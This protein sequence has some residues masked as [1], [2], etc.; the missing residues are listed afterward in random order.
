MCLE[1]TNFQNSIE[2]GLC[3]PF[4]F[5]Q[6]LCEKAGA[7]VYLVG[8][9]FR[10]R[11]RKAVFVETISRFGQVLLLFYAV[12][13]RFCVFLIAI[14]KKVQFCLLFLTVR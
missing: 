1:K 8:V 7:E 11:W 9:V 3:S 14:Q 13:I 2:C 5:W 10:H 12:C 4:C 6:F